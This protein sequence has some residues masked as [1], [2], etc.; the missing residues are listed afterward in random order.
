MGP[1]CGMQDTFFAIYVR[2]FLSTGDK[3]LHHRIYSLIADVDCKNSDVNYIINVA[4]FINAVADYKIGGKGTQK[5]S[6]LLV[7]FPAPNTINRSCWRNGCPWKCRGNARRMPSIFM[8]PWHKN[9]WFFLNLPTRKKVE[10]EVVWEI[11]LNRCSLRPKRWIRKKR[12][13]KSLIF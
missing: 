4:D 11:S 12:K 9:R 1:L 3:L 6:R 13:E 7:F 8:L 5:I 2:F 10:S